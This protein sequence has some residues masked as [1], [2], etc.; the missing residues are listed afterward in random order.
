MWKAC[1]M[2][3]TAGSASWQADF[4]PE[5]G[6]ALPAAPPPLPPQAPP[7]VQPPQVQ[8]PQAQPPQAQ[9]VQAQP[10]LAQL[11]ALRLPAAAPSLGH[12]HG[13]LPSP[14]PLPWRNYHL[15]PTT[16]S[17][18]QLFLYGRNSSSTRLGAPLPQPQRTALRA[19]AC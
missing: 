16:S 13:V 1:L 3:R 15:L 14:I 12:I 18:I 17:A 19:G 6:A 2:R 9:P 5:F 4:V 7:Q 8:P 11:P 10:P